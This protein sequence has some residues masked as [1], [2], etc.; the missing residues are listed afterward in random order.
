M[1]ETL[2]LTKALVELKLLSKRIDK[3]VDSLDPVA[4]KRGKQ[5]GG[6]FEASVKSQAEFERDTKAAWQALG[7][8]MRRRRKIKTALVLAN[9]STS[10][11]VAGETMTIAEA[12]ERKGMLDIE[13]LIVRKIRAKL[14]AAQGKVDAHNREMEGKLLKLLETTYAKKDAQLSK[15]DYERISKPFYE[16]NE[17]HLVDPLNCEKTVQKMEDAYEKFQAEVDVCLSIANAT[18]EITI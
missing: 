11:T 10:L 9:A 7:D 1:T 8:L 6:K 5:N 4:V 2:T 15:E 18:T 12:I 14:Y 17:M 3:R 16:S 13:Q